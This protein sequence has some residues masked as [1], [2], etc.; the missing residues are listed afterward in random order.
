[1]RSIISKVN[2]GM[3]LNQRDFE[4]IAELFDI[5]GSKGDRTDLENKAGK[6]DLKQAS[7]ILAQGELHID[8]RAVPRLGAKEEPRKDAFLTSSTSSACPCGRGT[9]P[10][11]PLKESTA[12]DA[13]IPAFKVDLGSRELLNFLQTVASPE[14]NKHASRG[15]TL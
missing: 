11:A 5:V 8:R 10:S 6:E 12:K 4:K 7:H 2:D 3:K 14:D 15:V 9:S 13:V 1:M